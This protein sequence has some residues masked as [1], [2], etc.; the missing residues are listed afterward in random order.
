MTRRPRGT[1]TG[2]DRL[3]RPR[4]CVGMFARAQGVLSGV[5][6]RATS[7]V[8][9]VVTVATLA[10]GA[11]IGWPRLLAALI[12]DHPLHPDP[13]L[14]PSRDVAV[15][16]RAVPDLRGAARPGLVCVAA[17]RPT[18][19]DP[20]NRV[21]GAACRH[22]RIRV[23]LD[24]GQPGAS[25]P[26]LVGGQQEAHVLPELLAGPL[27]HLERDPPAGR[28]RLPREDARLRRGHRG[29]LRDRRGPDA[30][31]RV[32]SPLARDSDPARR[33]V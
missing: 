17:C 26:T 33:C 14:P 5:S 32:Q 27:S 9:V 22:R 20:P 24:R 8:V 23:R 10:R 3:R 12:L 2:V 4:C 13:A 6:T 21:R 25:G 28:R 19:G 18:N 16:A 1:R 31:Q 7:A 15:P 11:F 30:G 29:L